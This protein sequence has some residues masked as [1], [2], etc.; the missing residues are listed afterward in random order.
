MQLNSEIARKNS[1]ISQ[2]KA[3]IAQLNTEVEKSLNMIADQQD[4]IKALKAQLVWTLLLIGLF[5][6]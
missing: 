3:L 1:E 2:L 6:G 5:R 4:E